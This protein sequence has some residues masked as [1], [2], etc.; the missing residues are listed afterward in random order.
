MFASAVADYQNFHMNR[1]G[2]QWLE[3]VSKCPATGM[4]QTNMIFPEGVTGV[5]QLTWLFWGAGG[6]EREFL[7]VCKSLVSVKM[8]RL[9]K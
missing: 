1:N 6:G 4:G 8:G 5:S 2:N 7:A 3:V 9:G